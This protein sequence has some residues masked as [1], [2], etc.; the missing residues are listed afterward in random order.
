[1]RRIESIPTT[2]DKPIEPVTI[3]AAGVLSPEEISQ[4]EQERKKAQEAAGGDDIW[5]DY[6]ADEEGVDAEK[7]EEALSVAA[8]LKDIGTKSVSPLVMASEE[9]S[10][11]LKESSRLVNLRLPST[12]TRRPCDI[13]IYIRCCLTMQLLS[14][15]RRSGHCEHASPVR[16][17]QC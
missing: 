11:E 1:M 4:A 5:E 9:K 17:R 16:C 8:K 14:R 2:S 12:S 10:D 3:A 7:A 13:S 15:S 6:P